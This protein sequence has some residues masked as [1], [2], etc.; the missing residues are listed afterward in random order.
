MKLINRFLH[1]PLKGPARLFQSENGVTI[2]KNGFRKAGITE[3]I[4]MVDFPEQDPF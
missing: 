2:I 4:E 1:L 3:A